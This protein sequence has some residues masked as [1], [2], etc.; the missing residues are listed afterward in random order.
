MERFMALLTEHW[1]GRW[2]RGGRERE[3]ARERKR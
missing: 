2:Y 3:R 1:T